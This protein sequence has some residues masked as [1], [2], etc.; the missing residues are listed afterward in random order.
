MPCPPEIGLDTDAG[1]VRVHPSLESTSN[2]GVFAAGDCA[3]VVGHPRPKAGVYAVRQGPPLAHNI[4]AKLLG[5][6]LWQFRP[7]SSH[8]VLFWC[9]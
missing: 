3:S 8:L 9:R 5:K 7:Q 1:F 2:P 4:R 6:P